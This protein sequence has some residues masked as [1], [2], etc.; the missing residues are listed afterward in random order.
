M[1]C[2]LCRCQ[3]V[4]RKSRWAGTVLTLPLLC[5][6]RWTLHEPEMN[7]WKRLHSVPPADGHGA[8]IRSSWKEPQLHLKHAT[9]ASCSRSEWNSRKHAAFGDSLMAPCMFTNF[10]FPPPLLSTRMLSCV[11]VRL[12]LFSHAKEWCSR[13]FLHVFSSFPFILRFSLK[14][15]SN[16]S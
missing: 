16:S 4:K 5:T 14:R 2:K 10:F 6:H 9:W 8:L 13:F 12:L 15:G 11:C 3:P 7:E 1:L